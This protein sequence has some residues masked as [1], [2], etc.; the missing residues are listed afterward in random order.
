MKNFQKTLLALA[1]S[2]AAV[3][4]N[5]ASTTGNFASTA[6]IS[7]ACTIAAT[8]MAFGAF[9]PTETPDVLGATSTLT[10]RCSNGV[11]Y[12]MTLDKGT[13]TSVADRS[14]PGTIG[15]NTDRLKY[16]IYQEA[17]YT[18]VFGLGGGVGEN[19]GLTGT[20]IDQSTTL[21]G[22]ILTNQFITPDAY[23]EQLTVTLTY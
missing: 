18:N 8:P 7:S 20:G 3:G 4:A 2:V 22:R 5:A 10:S 23:Q 12:T 16:N 14:M 6:T 11:F 17:A 15:G 21:Y 9:T 19:F 13:G 1:L